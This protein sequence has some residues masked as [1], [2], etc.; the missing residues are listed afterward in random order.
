MTSEH[1]FVL[2]RERNNQDFSESRKAE[3]QGLEKAN[4]FKVVN[5]NAV[6][7][8]SIICGTRFV[9]VLKKKD[10]GSVVAK[11]RLVAQNYC[12]KQAIHIPTKAP[13]ISRCGQRLG[14][15]IA[16]MNPDADSY[17]R[18]VTQAYIQ[19]KTSLERNVYLQPPSGMNLS[20]EKVLLAIKLLYGIP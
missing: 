10:D 19:S 12:D 18:D 1:G 17:I 15:C 11:S 4:V 3:L 14:L 6:P 9:D 13:T 5:R 7:V 16:A 20:S 8:G 2:P